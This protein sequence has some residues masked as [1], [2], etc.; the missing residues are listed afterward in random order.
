MHF[1]INITHAHHK[2]NKRYRKVENE[3]EKSHII[4]FFREKQISYFRYF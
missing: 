3:K 2:N 1:N 4:P